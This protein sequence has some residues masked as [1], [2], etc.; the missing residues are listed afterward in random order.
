MTTL[1]ERS[2]RIIWLFATGCMIILMGSVFLA[3]NLARTDY[4]DLWAI[5]LFPWAIAALIQG[6]QIQRYSDRVTGKVAGWFAI[7]I[8]MFG[9]ALAFIFGLDI[10]DLWPIIL[11]IVGAVV[12]LTAV[13]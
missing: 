2:P 5:G 3:E 4:D 13:R 10:G 9:V 7:G 6:R 12:A 1:T 11:I 8:T